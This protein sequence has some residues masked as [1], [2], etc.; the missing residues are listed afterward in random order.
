MAKELPD[1]L[2]LQATNRQYFVL[3]GAA[4]LFVIMLM[5]MRF[6][7]E[8]PAEEI[9][10]WLTVFFSIVTFIGASAA[11]M[12]QPWLTLDREGFQ[13]SELK[14]IGKVAWRD[15]SEF[16]L[17]RYGGSGMPATNQVAFKLSDNKRKTL[18]RMSSMLFSG[19]V[20]LTEHYRVNGRRLVQVMNQFRERAMQQGDV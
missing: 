3:A 10:I 4:A 7:G 20:R 8:G 18:P 6:A 19:T 12:K 9:N 13:S 1:H 2:H 14:S 17:Y 5:W 15:V 16:S 11:L